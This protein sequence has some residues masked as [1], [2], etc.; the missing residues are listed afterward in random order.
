MLE[1]NSIA[2][3]PTLSWWLVFFCFH[4]LSQASWFGPRPNSSWR[5]YSPWTSTGLPRSIIRSHSPDFGATTFLTQFGSCDP[6]W[7]LRCCWCYWSKS[8]CTWFLLAHQ[9]E[10]SWAWQNS[11]GSQ[12]QID[13]V[14][15]GCRRILHRPLRIFSE[16]LTDCSAVF[17]VCFWNSCNFDKCL[18]RQVPFLGPKD[19]WS[20]FPHFCS[21]LTN[22][23]DR[24]RTWMLHH[25]CFRSI[26]EISW[27]RRIRCISNHIWPAGSTLCFF[28]WILP[29]CSLDLK[30]MGIWI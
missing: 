27:S 6:Y 15:P 1:I 21:Q 20:Y 7:F 23:R 14:W 16:F 24:R 29:L 13:F 30:K 8:R 10:D 17:S 4:S 2:S 28:Q 22:N 19:S 18:L 3:Y 25:L 5:E 12:H 26:G 11:I 9:H